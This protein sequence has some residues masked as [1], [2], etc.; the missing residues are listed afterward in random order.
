MN[1]RTSLAFAAAALLAAPSLAAA[2]GMSMATPSPRPAPLN[3]TEQSFYERASAT[4]R[5]LYPNPAAAEKAGYLRFSNED[6]TGA[7]SYVNPNYFNTPEDAHPQQLWFDING[8]LL[9]ADFSQTVAAHPRPTL[10]ELQPNRFHHITAHVH[11]GLK[12]PDGSIRYGLYVPASTYITVGD[13][14]HPTAEGLVKLGKATSAAQVAFVV[15]IFENWDAQMWVIPNP[16][17]QFAD[18]NPNVKPSA[19]QGGGSGEEKM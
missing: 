8:R 12:Q 19:H 11:F 18:A 1:R 3:A 9:G 5:R 16:A 15:A 10:F 17:G 4:L 6:S 2:Q 13:P 7:I 14:L